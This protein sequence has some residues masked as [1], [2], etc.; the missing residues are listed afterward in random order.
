MD[1]LTHHAALRR[2][3][4]HRRRFRAS[5]VG[6][7]GGSKVLSPQQVR[8]QQSGHQSQQLGRHSL[9]R[10]SS[11]GYGFA[12]QA[13]TT[14]S[15][16]YGELSTCEAGR[17]GSAA[18]A[19]CWEEDVSW[20]AL[21]SPAGVKVSAADLTHPWTWDVAQPLTTLSEGV[22]VRATAAG[23]SEAAEPPKPCHFV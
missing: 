16:Q 10:I 5:R 20:Q 15:F 7:R 21:V 6:S 19:Q 17:P 9:S 18:Q 2:Q 12:K 11:A 3:H 22:K 1:R 13:R 8:Q 23:A 4:Q 14:G